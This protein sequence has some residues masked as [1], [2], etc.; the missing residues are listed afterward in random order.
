MRDPPG[1]C[2]TALV[3]AGRGGSGEAGSSDPAHSGCFPPVPL[4]PHHVLFQPLEKRSLSG[5]RRGVWSWDPP[6]VPLSPGP[7][8]SMGA[9]SFPGS[10][11]RSC[12]CR[13]PDRMPYHRR[14][15]RDSD[16]YRCDE[17]SPSFAEDYYSTRAR[18]W[19]RSRG[20]EQH[21]ARK[22]QHHCQKRR[23]RSCSSA[24]SVSSI[25]NELRIAQG[26]NCSCLLPA[27]SAG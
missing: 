3:C 20:R 7:L 14:C 6:V 11:S 9:V 22:Y 4:S 26:F 1:G 2:D 16:A 17:R 25:Q 8:G 23:T 13:S 19:R 24:S 18:N 15:R 27:R 10:Q 5:S 12:L 21:R